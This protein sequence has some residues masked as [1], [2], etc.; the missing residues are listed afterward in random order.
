VSF[1]KTLQRQ[2]SGVIFGAVA[3]IVV[4]VRCV[5]SVVSGRLG[6]VCAIWLVCVWVRLFETLSSF[7]EV[8]RNERTF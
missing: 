7:L 8:V 1:G 3:G 6:S 2:V 4:S 5:F